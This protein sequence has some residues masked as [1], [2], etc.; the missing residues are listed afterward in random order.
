[1][2]YIVYDGKFDFE[3]NNYAGK[4]FATL[5]EARKYAELILKET[6]KVVAVEETNLNVTYEFKLGEEI[7]K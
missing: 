7:G 4:V 1:M 2:N 6:K 3:T 5:N